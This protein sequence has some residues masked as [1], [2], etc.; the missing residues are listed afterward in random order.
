MAWQFEVGLNLALTS[1]VENESYNCCLSEK[2]N[3]A[4][5]LKCHSC[6]CAKKNHIKG[7]TVK[8]SRAF[9]ANSQHKSNQ[10]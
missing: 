7:R 5:V 6:T 2:S 4:E 1:I 9:H 3:G 8:D 10:I